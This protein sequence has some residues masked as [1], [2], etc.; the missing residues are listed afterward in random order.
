MVFETNT[1]IT[2]AQKASM[3]EFIDNIRILMNTLGYKILEQV[4]QAKDD[5]VYLFC[6]GKKSGASAKGFVS[7]NGFT[8][9]KRNM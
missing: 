7:A 2:E 1:V 8:V 9:V 5:T 4:P 3:E 6:K